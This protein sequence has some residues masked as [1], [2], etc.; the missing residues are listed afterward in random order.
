[1]CDPVTGLPM[2]PD[3]SSEGNYSGERGFKI[4]NPAKTPRDD[5]VNIQ[6]RLKETRNRATFE[7]E[8][9]G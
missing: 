5:D 9:N 6:S 8:D 1:M 7:I 3:M 4:M 2:A